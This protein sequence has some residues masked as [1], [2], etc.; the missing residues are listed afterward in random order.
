M[1]QFT[2]DVLRHIFGRLSSPEAQAACAQTCKSWNRLE[3]EARRVIHLNAAA[4]ILPAQFQCSYPGQWVSFTLADSAPVIVEPDYKTFSLE[5]FGHS[6]DPWLDVLGF[7][8]S[9]TSLTLENVHVSHGAL[10]A[11]L[12]RR[13]GTLRHLRLESV[14]GVDGAAMG[15]IA[16]HCHK[17]ESLAVGLE[18]GS[19]F[20]WATHFLLS[21]SK[22][23]LTGLS[24]SD[25]NTAPPAL[26]APLIS[27][28]S[29]LQSIDLS[30][31]EMWFFQKD[32]S[33]IFA[34]VAGLPKLTTLKLPFAIGQQDLLLFQ[35][36]LLQV[37]KL[38]LFD[39]EGFAQ[40]APSLSYLVELSAFGSLERY[41]QIGLRCKRLQT[42]SFQSQ[43]GETAPV[44]LRGLQS[45]LL[46]CKRL[47]ELSLSDLDLGEMHA[48]HEIAA[49]TDE[50]SRLRALR[51]GWYCHSRPIA[52]ER[53][54]TCQIL[55][56]C[57]NL[58]HLELSFASESHS[59]DQELESVSQ[60]CR[61]LR[62]LKVER[63]G[64]S[65][66]SL[67]MIAVNCKELVSLTLVQVAVGDVAVAAIARHCKNLKSLRLVDSKLS[68]FGVSELAAGLPSLV[69]LTLE[70]KQ[71]A[72]H[73]VAGTFRQQRFMHLPQS[74]KRPFDKIGSQFTKARP[75]WVAESYAGVHRASLV[76]Y[77][78]L[79]TSNGVLW[80]FALQLC[81]RAYLMIHRPLRGQ[82]FV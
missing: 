17:L 22:G 82:G 46:G 70:R 11:F 37:S 69:T 38:E 62:H 61:S 28:F 30:S 57:A 5:S 16:E 31:V 71:K 75:L 63:V 49:I 79:I 50:L 45:V 26:V 42:V 32:G 18:L 65:D 48:A 68:K 39:A 80:C 44:E 74:V 76:A 24:S 3:R 54:N 9:L 6:A 58:T 59:R 64:S 77:P 29:G 4:G 34:A 13:G 36:V 60:T 23:S 43:D 15:L 10:A 7:K 12:R 21:P 51:L 35:S 66:R 67:A 81:C 41:R 27:A 78:V 72:V 40:V 25:W 8:V 19:S 55:E 73:H 56:S 20:S 14:S 33:R 2:D 52:V 47:Q 1:N 53:R